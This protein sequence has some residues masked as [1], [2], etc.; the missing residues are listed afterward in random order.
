VHYPVSAMP[1]NVNY[2]VN[3]SN[4]LMLASYSVKDILKLRWFAVA[5]ALTNIPYFLLQ[6][7][8]L[9]PPVF[10]AL[11]FSVINSYQIWRI[12]MERRPVALS[13]DE[14]TLYDM[15]FHALRPRDFVRLVMAG[16]WKNAAAGDAILTEGQPTTSISIPIAGSVRIRRHGTDVGDL[17]PGHVLGTA[18][19]LTGQPA[20]VD[21]SFNTPGRYINWPV[22]NV[23]TLLNRSPEL[24]QIIQGMVNKDLAAKV[25]ELE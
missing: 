13:P 2:L 11:V 1:F 18:A 21:A 5:A 6:R 22:M 10:W 7:E 4:L 16:Q 17:K 25:E 14:Q 9:W 8:V 24:R 19:A 23:E 20:H 15:G 12:Y 3:F